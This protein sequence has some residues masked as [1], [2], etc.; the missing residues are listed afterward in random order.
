LAL[1]LLASGLTLVG[2]STVVTVAVL[3]AIVL[4]GPPLWAWA[5][6]RHGMPPLAAQ[7]R[8]MARVG[9]RQ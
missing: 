7:E 9:N 5:R 2:A 1:V 4:A 8:R 6:V 3:G